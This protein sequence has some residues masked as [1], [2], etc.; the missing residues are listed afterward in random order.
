MTAKEYS[1]MSIIDNLFSGSAKKN[2][3]FGYDKRIIMPKSAQDTIPFYEVYDNGLFLTG[4]NTFTLIFAF[5][6]IDY[7]LLRD[8]EQ[9]ETYQRCI[10]NYPYRLSESSHRKHQSCFSN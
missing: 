2:V 4:V 9:E 8:K 6:N 1:T 3:P 10:I 7:S 5:S